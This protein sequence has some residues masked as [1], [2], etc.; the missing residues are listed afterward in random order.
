MFTNAAHVMSR[1]VSFR[2]ITTVKV[3]QNRFLANVAKI[4]IFIPFGHTSGINRTSETVDV[5]RNFIGNV[6]VGNVNGESDALIGDSFKRQIQIES[7]PEM[8]TFIQFRKLFRC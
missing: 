8:Q 4:L 1:L 3:I 5:V 7:K 6:V 2:T